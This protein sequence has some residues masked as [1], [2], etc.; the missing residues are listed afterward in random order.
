[1]A[2]HTVGVFAWVFPN[3]AEDQALEVYFIFEN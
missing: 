3:K 1:M 2:A